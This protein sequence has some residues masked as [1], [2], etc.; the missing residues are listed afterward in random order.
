MRRE[1]SSG[2]QRTYMTNTIFMRTIRCILALPL[3]P[4]NH[5]SEIYYK[6]RSRVDDAAPLTLFDYVERQWIIST[7]HPLK[8]ISVFVCQS[9]P[10]MTA[11]VII[12]D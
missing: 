6:L 3:L 4:F 12:T 5:I 1:K 11:R 10:T 9:V 8:S 7:T 2:L